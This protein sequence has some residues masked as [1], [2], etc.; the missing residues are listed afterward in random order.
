[1]S[2][3]NFDNLV[4][5][6]DESDQ[7]VTQLVIEP[8]EISQTSRVMSLRWKNAML[9]PNSYLFFIYFLDNTSRKF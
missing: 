3:H 8:S 2:P 6:E 1:M 9:L 4:F 7:E 5:Y